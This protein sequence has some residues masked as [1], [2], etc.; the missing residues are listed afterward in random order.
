VAVLDLL[1]TPIFGSY[2]L[3]QTL[4]IATGAV[5]TQLN[6][7]ALA[8]TRGEEV[9]QAPSIETR[10]ETPPPDTANPPMAAPFF[11]ALRTEQAESFRMTPGNIV[12]SSGT[13][14]L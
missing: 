14:N 13:T 12:D 2:P 10:Y 8:D 1:F 9:S 6:K 3:L 4:S 11:T 5:I 7:A